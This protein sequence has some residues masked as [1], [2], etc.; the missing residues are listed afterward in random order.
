MD[1]LQLAEKLLPWSEDD[2]VCLQNADL[3]FGWLYKKGEC[4][5]AIECWKH[6]TLPSVS[7]VTRN[8]YDKQFTI[9]HPVRPGIVP[10]Q[11]GK[12]S[13]FALDFDAHEGQKPNV[14]LQPKTARFFQTEPVLF[15]S[16]SGRG[17]RAIFLLP[18]PMDVLEFLGIIR[19]WG[20]NRR[21][22]IEL[23]PKTE[24]LTQFWLPND[25]NPETGGDTF[26]S[27]MWENA[28]AILP[29]KVPASLTNAT[30]DCLL[31]FVEPGSRHNA[32]YAAAREMGQKRIQEKV[33]RK[34]LECG[35]QLC[36]LDPREAS[37]AARDGYAR[38]LTDN[39]RPTAF[40]EQEEACSLPE[41][42]W[43]AHY[44]KNGI[45]ERKPELI[46]GILRQSHKM[47]IGAPSKACKSFL[48][49]RLALAIAS[50]HDWLGF[51]CKK[52]NVYVANFE[53]DEGSYLHRVQAVA[54]AL[55]WPMPDNIAY[56]HLRGY[57]QNIEELFPSIV[58][59]I[60]GH[61]IST[62]ILDPQYK[63]LRSSEIRNF[64]END[65]VAMGYLYGELD[66][67]FS[68]NGFSTII[69]SHFAKGL[70]A[71]KEAIDR[72]AGSGAP[73]RDVDAVCTL[74]A[75]ESDDAYRMEFSLREFKTPD[76]LSLQWG[77][78]IHTADPMLDSVP[79]K[80]PGR[81]GANTGSDDDLVF[82]TVQGLNG[83]AT[84]SAV[85]AAVA[86]QLG[87]NRTV[88]ALERLVIARKLT[89]SKGNKNATVYHVA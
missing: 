58:A 63:L 12:V 18:G 32:L 46:C 40:Q 80:K 15:K 82:T 48:A 28:V 29:Q 61:A 5:K 47:L 57:G 86:G 23:F 9:A 42:V 2:K 44:I 10:H 89:T 6:G 8:K 1:R 49:I 16:K 37:E 50:G 77:Y 34:L 31:G 85:R 36:G 39:Q 3:V 26:I 76:P 74:S 38:G 52:G 21:D 4:Q 30:L 83:S 45:P 84:Q 75:L 72:I 43:G 35:A 33:S 25:P 78:P 70:A 81:P 59:A 65:T 14:D 69:I 41:I 79:L 13:Y 68:R 87:R 11:A 64:S 73:M 67:Y 56:H 53:I 60:D 88:D 51:P 20:F 54:D 55:R 71:S 17:I 19:S 62:V 7:F 24:K 22:R 66:R 27:G